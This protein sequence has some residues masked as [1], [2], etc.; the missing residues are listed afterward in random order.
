MRTIFNTYV[1]LTGRAMFNRLQKACDEKGLRTD[2]YTEGDYFHGN[3][4]K[5]FCDWCGLLNSQTEVTEQ[6]FLELLKEYKP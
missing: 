6:E 3:N 4:A 2:G 5:K 1:A